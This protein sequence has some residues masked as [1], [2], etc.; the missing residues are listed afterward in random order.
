MSAIGLV[1]VGTESPCDSSAILM[2]AP[3]GYVNEQGEYVG[4]PDTIPLIPPEP[5]QLIA[6]TSTIEEYNASDHKELLQHEFYEAGY[7]N[8][9]EFI[10]DFHAPKP[11]FRYKGRMPDEKNRR[12]I[13]NTRLFKRYV[14]L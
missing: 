9:N 11:S 14:Q 4:F 2:N 3:R 1:N 13:G 10:V 7:W 12:D 8:G 6:Y 5:E